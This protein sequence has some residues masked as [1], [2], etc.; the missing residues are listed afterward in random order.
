MSTVTIDWVPT[1]Y[2]PLRRDRR[3][4]LPRTGHQCRPQGVPARIAPEGSMDVVHRVFYRVLR[5]VTGRIKGDR[6]VRSSLA[7]CCPTSALYTIDDSQ[8]RDLRG[9]E[10]PTDAALVPFATLI[11]SA[12][13]QQFGS[14]SD[15]LSRRFRLN[16]YGAGD[17]SHSR[18]GP[19]F[20]RSG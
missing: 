15:R 14:R 10:R 11:Q 12:C 18:W 8:I 16:C 4:P 17:G 3:R 7:D 9:F 19:R 13:M 2:D 5:K 6:G 20:F 1:R